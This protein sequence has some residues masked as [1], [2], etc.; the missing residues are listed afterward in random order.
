MH[1]KFI[2]VLFP[3]VKWSLTLDNKESREPIALENYD[4]FIISLIVSQSRIKGHPGRLFCV[5]EDHYLHPSFMARSA[6]NAK[7]SFSKEF[8]LLV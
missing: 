1:E 2:N 6:N 3:A 4:K 5:E 8:F 7:E